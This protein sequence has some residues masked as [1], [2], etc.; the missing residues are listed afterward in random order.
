MVHVPLLSVSM[1]SN[2]SLSPLTSS[3]DM[4]WAMNCRQGE[5]TAQHARSCRKLELQDWTGLRQPCIAAKE[6]TSSLLHA[7]IIQC[8]SLVLGSH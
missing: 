2:I 8:V 6:S 7:N 5:S 1:L 4:L 3:A